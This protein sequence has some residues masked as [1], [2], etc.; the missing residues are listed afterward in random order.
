M[1]QGQTLLGSLLNFVPKRHF[2][3]LARTFKANRYTKSFP[4]WAHF[5]CMTFAHLTKQVGLRDLETALNSNSQHL[6]H[7]GLRHRPSRS[8]MADAAKRRDW[9]FFEALGL[10]LIA[11]YQGVTPLQREPTSEVGSEPIPLGLNAQTIALGLKLFPWI[12]TAENV[13]KGIDASVSVSL[14]GTMPMLQRLTAQAHLNAKFLKMVHKQ[15]HAVVLLMCDSLDFDQIGA[16]NRQQNHFV[17]TVSQDLAYTVSLEMPLPVDS[18]LSELQ[19]QP[20]AAVI[21]SD[22]CILLTDTQASNAYPHKIRLVTFLPDT[23]DATSAT[24]NAE[25][26]V[27]LTNRYDLCA[28]TIAAIYLERESLESLFTWLS[29]NTS[30]KRILGSS[31]NAVTSH[32]WITVCVYLMVLTARKQLQLDIG[33]NELMGALGTQVF[34]KITIPELVASVQTPS[35]TSQLAVCVDSTSRSSPNISKANSKASVLLTYDVRRANKGVTLGSSTTKSDSQPTAK[36][37]TSGV[38]SA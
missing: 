15:P 18:P 12:V 8:T 32:V 26:L 11:D 2:E 25:P 10:R 22:Q 17:A 33:Q 31:Q 5:V 34:S 7:L 30:A 4:A 37:P 28:Q 27:L 1:Y 38:P 23:S 19:R 29:H 9:R 13:D 6:Y 3:Y 14:R 35:I 16:L 20:L 36:L 24:D 21:V